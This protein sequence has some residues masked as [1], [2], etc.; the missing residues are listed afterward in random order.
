MNLVYLWM[1]LLQ[2]INMTTITLNSSVVIRSALKAKQE[3]CSNFV[4]TIK[5]LYLHCKN[6]YSK[7]DS[8]KTSKNINDRND[9]PK[10]TQTMSQK[11]DK[12]QS[13]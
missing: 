2:G 3:K 4:I 5:H 13:F 6:M 7:N 10:M 9:V 1:N 8:D 11:M 12:T